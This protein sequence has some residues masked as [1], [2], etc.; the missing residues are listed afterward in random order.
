M[1]SKT[2]RVSLDLN[3]QATAEIERMRAITGLNTADLFRHAVTLLR[4]YIQARAGGKEFRIVDPNDPSD[5]VRLEM[6]ISVDA[7]AISAARVS[8]KVS[9]STTG[10]M[11]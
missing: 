7:P 1:A 11:P 8:K 3:P 6:P 10:A 4:L 5:Q 9:P 2:K